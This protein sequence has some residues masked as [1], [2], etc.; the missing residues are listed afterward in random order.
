MTPQ[1]GRGM[2]YGTRIKF[3]R[4]IS[5]LTVIGVVIKLVYKR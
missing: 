3:Y 4:K 2:R 1:G 5:S